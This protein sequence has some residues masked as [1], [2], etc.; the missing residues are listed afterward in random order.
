MDRREFLK[1]SGQAALAIGAGLTL[2][3]V[4]SG[5][6]T[7]VSEDEL[8]TTNLKQQENI[9]YPHVGKA[10]QKKIQ[11]PAEGCYIGFRRIVVSSGSPGDQAAQFKKVREYYSKMKDIGELSAAI[12]KE[13]LKAED[14]IRTRTNNYVDYYQRLLGKTPFALMIFETVHLCY[15]FPTLEAEVLAKKGVTPF[16]FAKVGEQQPLNK[17]ENLNLQDIIKCAYDNYFEEFAEGARQ[18]GEN[19]GGFFLSTMQE[20]NGSWHPWASDPNTFKKAWQHIWKLFEEKGANQYATW[21][22][23]PDAPDIGAPGN[24]TSDNPDWYYP[25]DEFV[26]WIA[27]SAYARSSIPH[28]DRSYKALNETIY[29][30]MRKN[31]SQ[32]PLMQSEFGKSADARQSAWLKDALQTIKSWPEMKAAIYWDIYDNNVT[33]VDDYRLDAKSIEA[34]KEALNRDN[35]FIMAK[36]A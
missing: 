28:Q 2:E 8:A 33:F 21:V 3:E 14:M 26:D 17:V 23:S 19:Y 13:R 12:A 6:A 22:W 35:Y 15:R 1:K 25:G 27:W 34:V 5:C 29:R 16:F 9:I 31:H 32:K 7:T 36:Q 10:D 18:F 20:M 30:Q 4:L 24:K 11:P